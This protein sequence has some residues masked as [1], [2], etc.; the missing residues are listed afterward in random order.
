M[1]VDNMTLQEVGE[2]ILKAAINYYPTIMSKLAYKER[3]YRRIVIKGL[4][5]RYD[6]KPIPFKAYGIEFYLCP[7][8]LG[9]S[10]FKKF[11]IAYCLFA[12]VYYRGTNWYCLVMNDFC[13]LQ[14]YCNHFFERYIERHLKD[15]SIVNAETVRKYFKETDY[16]TYNRVIENPRHDN[17]LYATTKIG[18]CCGEIITENVL[19]YK[20]YIDEE[21]IIRGG[22]KEAFD[23]GTERLDAV[24]TNEMGL[25]EIPFA[26]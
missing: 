6:F 26:A 22:K 18:I 13:G 19:V 10:D 11:G 7:Y 23:F 12:H 17:C 2:A 14:M 25:R 21:T 8:A 16:L 15:D 24:I 5:D 1:I 20:T 9:K 3:D 4:K